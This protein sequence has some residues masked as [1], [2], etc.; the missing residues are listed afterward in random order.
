VPAGTLLAGLGLL[1]RDRLA[2]RP[3]AVRDAVVR[4]L[5]GLRLALR[6]A[7][8]PWRNRTAWSGLA[9]YW[10]G[11]VFSLWAA[12]QAFRTGLGFTVLVLAFATGYAATRR[13]IPLAGA[14]TTE[15]LMPFA[16]HWLG[17]ALAPAVVAVLAYRAVNLVL[18]VPPA[19][20][21]RGSVESVVRRGYRLQPD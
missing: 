16:L 7:S 8:H 5:D 12:L 11:E 18:C 9:I 13:T 20:A 4:A 14:G 6:L 1:G 3:G 15:V 17:V 21:V 10:A 19:L 2:R